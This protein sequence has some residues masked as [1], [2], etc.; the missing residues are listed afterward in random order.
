MAVAFF[1]GRY[2]RKKCTKHH[3]YHT[4]RITFLAAKSFFLIADVKK[5]LGDFLAK[6]KSV[7]KY[8]LYHRKCLM[9]TDFNTTD[10]RRSLCCKQ[11]R[12]SGNM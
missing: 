11:V 2:V 4:M 8:L 10:R 12:I 9:E 3:V 7:E 5:K 6:D 1:E